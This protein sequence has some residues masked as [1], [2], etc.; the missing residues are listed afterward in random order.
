MGR[1]G[2]DARHLP[3][4]VPG[5]PATMWSR[6]GGIPSPRETPAVLTLVFP[7]VGAGA[8]AGAASSAGR[9]A[10]RGGSSPAGA[11]PSREPRAPLWGDREQPAPWAP[12]PRICSRERGAGRAFPLFPS[13]PV[14]HVRPTAVFPCRIDLNLNSLPRF[15]LLSFNTL[16]GPRWCVILVVHFSS[17]SVH[18]LGCTR[19]QPNRNAPVQPSHMT[20][21]GAGIGGGTHPACTHCFPKPAWMG[22][23]WSPMGQTQK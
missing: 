19:E 14:S 21:C 3:S 9:T 17:V 5:P 23:F 12:A 16:K 13:K 22:P 15:Y 1:R 18:S 11:P 10:P 4:A 20:S 2:G 8:T 7:Q 6:D